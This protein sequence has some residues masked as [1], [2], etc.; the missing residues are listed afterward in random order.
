MT[1]SNEIRNQ[2]YSAKDKQKKG[3]EQ[4]HKLYNEKF[5]AGAQYA[6]ST[7]FSIYVHIY[8]FVATI[9]TIINSIPS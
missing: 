8:Y 5:L 7:S 4:E 3:Q 9:K 6:S 2:E 1:F